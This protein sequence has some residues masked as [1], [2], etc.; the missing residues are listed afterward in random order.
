MML[1]LVEVE[2]NVILWI[3]PELFSFVWGDERIMVER[4]K[5]ATAW[6]FEHKFTHVTWK[7]V[8]KVSASFAEENFNE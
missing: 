7:T 3:F 2:S 4:G 1:Q 6:S 8:K 5:V